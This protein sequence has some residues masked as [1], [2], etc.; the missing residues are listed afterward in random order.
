MLGTLYGVGVGPGDPE[1]MTLKAMR[2]IREADVAA[3]PGKIPQETLAY[4][5]AIQAVPEL[6]EKELAAIYMPMVHNQETLL[7]NHIEGA[8]TLE[9]YLS[10][11]KNVV[12]L[13]LGDP[14]VYSTFTYLQSIVADHGYPT[15]LING[16]TSFCAAAA[17]L[18]LPLAEW[19]E[20]LQI[21]PAVH[22]LERFSK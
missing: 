11:G 3:L 16:V 9:T 1:L 18:N 13:T 14:T 21:L 17:K 4:Q 15:A 7:R 10:R 22:C 8:R 20:P 19:N 12:F 2:L 5:I 6:A